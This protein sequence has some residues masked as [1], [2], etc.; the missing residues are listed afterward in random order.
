MM[1]CTIYV[2]DGMKFNY[3]AAARNFKDLF[4]GEP[5][6]VGSHT[7]KVLLAGDL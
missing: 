2:F 5:M 3:N 1:L 6:G 4:Y 7:Y